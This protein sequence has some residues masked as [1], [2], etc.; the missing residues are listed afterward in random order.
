MLY[1]DPGFSI[2]TLAGKLKV[3]GFIRDRS[4]RIQLPALLLHR[5]LQSEELHHPSIENPRARR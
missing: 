1:Y 4:R 2:W 5:A 3:R